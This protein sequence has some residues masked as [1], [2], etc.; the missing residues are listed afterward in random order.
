MNIK[1]IGIALIATLLFT[2]GC[3][4][5]WRRKFVRS[6][7]DE[8]KQGPVLQPYDYKKE[9]TNKQ[10]YANH[11]VFWKNSEAELINSVKAKGNM[12]KIKSHA[13]YSLVEIRK[14]SNLLND[15]KKAQIEP[16][17]QELEDIVKKI[18]QPSY[19][20]SNSNRIVSR[21]S[22]H[23]RAVRS[24]FSFFHMKHFVIK[25]DLGGASDEQ[26]QDAE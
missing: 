4:G 18:Q 5:G 3:S 13:A 21:L 2:T 9:F 8:V 19:V 16:Y 1:I 25:D 20:K 26:P 24:G 11:Y 23:Y 17:V 6:K 10:L 14:L 22:K 7:K 12:K 15:E